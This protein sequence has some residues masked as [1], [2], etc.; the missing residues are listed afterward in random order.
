M[1]VVDF[2]GD[3]LSEVAHFVD[4]ANGSNFWGVY[5]HDHPDGNT[6]ILGSDRNTGL[7]IFDTP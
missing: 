6:Y 2:G 5:L 1:R 4:T 3:S 7:W